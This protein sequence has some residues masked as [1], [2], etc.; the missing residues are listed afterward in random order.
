MALTIALAKGRLA[1]FA[2]KLFSKCGLDITQLEED[3]RK[4]VVYDEKNDIRFVLVKPA[5][6]PVYVYRG[7]ADIGIAGKDTLLEAGL[8][9]Y[10]ML[11][12]RCGTCKI[13][14][15]GYAEKQKER[16]TSSITRVATKYP[17]I[18]KMYYDEKGEDI[19][20]IKLNGSIELAP[21][22]DLSDVI[23]DIVESGATIRENG[24]SVLEEVCDVS[25][26]LVVNQVSLKTK[27]EQIQPLIK[28]MSKALEE[29]Q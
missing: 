7:V 14:V 19:E 15:A 22:L 18:A 28:A 3:N 12:L 5:D 25:A 6:V 27:T 1:K 9:L 13:C 8:P 2:T 10:E 21:I 17:R 29:M 20:I 26:R 11:D 24:L 16:I 23:V 4:L